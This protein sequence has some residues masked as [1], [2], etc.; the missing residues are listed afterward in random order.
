[1]GNKNKFLALSLTSAMLTTSAGIGIGTYWTVFEL[2][3]ETLTPVNTIG[4]SGN[5]LT[6]GSSTSDTAVNQ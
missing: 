3:G 2:D 6:G 5:L 1:M 4:R